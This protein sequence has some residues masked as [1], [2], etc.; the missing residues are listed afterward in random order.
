MAQIPGSVPLTGKVA[1]TDDTDTFA[2]HVDIYGEG[3]YMTVADIAERNAITSERRK[4]GMAVFVND[5]NELYILEDGVANTNWQLFSGGGGSGSMQ[6]VFN[7]SSPNV[8]AIDQSKS[9][10]L[11][12]HEV[13]LFANN[14]DP[15]A[16]VGSTGE[17]TI[18]SMDAS[19]GHH[20]TPTWIKLRGG[21]FGAGELNIAGVAGQSAA[22]AVGDV[23][24]IDSID[25]ANLNQAKM[26]FTSAS[27]I[28][29]GSMQ[30][31][32]DNSTP[33]IIATD[34]SKTLSLSAGTTNILTA[35]S[36]GGSGEITIQS[37]DAGKIVELQLDA[38]NAEVNLTSYGLINTK[39]IDSGVSTQRFGEISTELNNQ[40]FPGA[41]VN[42][43][44]QG[45]T[46]D[47]NVLTRVSSSRINQ[48]ILEDCVLE[49]SP[50][51][52]TTLLNSWKN[53]TVNAD[54]IMLVQGDRV[55][56]RSITDFTELR[57]ENSAINGSATITQEY[58][59]GTNGYVNRITAS[60]SVGTNEIV[61]N[62][63]DVLINIAG[64][65]L[66][67]DVLASKTS[68][69]LA[70]LEWQPGVQQLKVNLTEAEVQALHTSAI[71]II[72]SGGIPSGKLLNVL[73]VLCFV[74]TQ[75]TNSETLKFYIDSCTAGGGFSNPIYQADLITGQPVGTGTYAG[76]SNSAQSFGSNCQ[77]LTV[78][79]TGA[80]GVPVNSGGVGGIDVYVSY[81]FIDK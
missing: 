26:K 34:A 32:F 73:N 38:T 31:V 54:E 61:V 81:Q 66:T 8:D 39:A 67:G 47:N 7:A 20:N 45:A 16:P 71:D 22:P 2:T 77:A 75:F 64:G 62:E 23:L 6:D 48:G 78:K 37:D 12:A 69:A 13:T 36:S 68:G 65:A 52:G 30:D 40:G 80:S 58:D 18:A 49:L 53:T 15:N 35:T 14:D 59:G 76:R 55:E 42:I 27:S 10:A 74:D 41:V 25:A 24:I 4:Q 28:S 50:V 43:K 5:T 60:G 56:I 57:N 63:K 44:S 19:G 21:Q 3:G 17:L 11:T 9:L 29:T 72:L 79:L 70:Q 33:N 1:P 46:G 51:G